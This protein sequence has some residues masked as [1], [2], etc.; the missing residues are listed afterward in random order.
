MMMRIQSLNTI[1]DVLLSG[2][3]LISCTSFDA[4]YSAVHST[5][6]Q[7][8]A[9]KEMETQNAHRSSSM[10][11]LSVAVFQINPS[12]SLFACQIHSLLIPLVKPL[13]I[14]LNS[15]G[16]RI[17]CPAQDTQDIVFSDE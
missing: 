6:E 7:E 13:T 10:S 1:K 17:R 2:L 5:I 4:L 3:R 12:N 14:R 8:L 16:L 11:S 9:N 15:W